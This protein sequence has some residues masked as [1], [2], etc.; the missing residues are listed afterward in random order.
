MGK[1]DY[2]SIFL[3]KMQ[4]FVFLTPELLKNIH[5]DFEN[6]VSILF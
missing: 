1:Q 6:I 2:I 3:V 5:L 4:I